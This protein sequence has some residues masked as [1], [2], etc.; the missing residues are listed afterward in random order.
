MRDALG[1]CGRSLLQI[2]YCIVDVVD[3]RCMS[4]I[5]FRQM[6]VYMHDLQMFY[7]PQSI[8][9]SIKHSKTNSG[10]LCIVCIQLIQSTFV[11]IQVE[12]HKLFGSASFCAVFLWGELYPQF[13][14]TSQI[15]LIV[16]PDG[17]H[18]SCHARY[19]ETTRF[20]FEIPRSYPSVATYH[21]RTKVVT[22]SALVEA[23]CCFCAMVWAV[24]Q[25]D[26]QGLLKFMRSIMHGAT[27]LQI[28]NLEWSEQVFCTQYLFDCGSTVC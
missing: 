6:C 16:S 11:E 5:E 7:T 15:S 25:L 4:M 20:S 28:L 2:E 21:N 24:D 23:R 9:T 10:D 12:F 3:I 22:F 14:T 8:N 19:C 26:L 27:F 1:L 18:I 17:T 13:V